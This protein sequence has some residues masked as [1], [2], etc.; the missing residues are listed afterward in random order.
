MHTVIGFMVSIWKMP[1]YWRIWIGLLMLV[2]G[3]A[4]LLYL[5]TIE[6][7]VVLTVFVIAALTQVIIFHYKGFV[8]LLGIGHIYWIPLI[9]WVL[10]RLIEE[11]FIEAVQIWMGSLIVLNTTSLII[12]LADVIRYWRGE[13]SATIT[14]P[15]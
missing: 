8:R 5:D 1:W 12:D 11:P 2:N 6:S 13:K 15:R 3:I 7:K 4:P 14:V 10:I 9:G